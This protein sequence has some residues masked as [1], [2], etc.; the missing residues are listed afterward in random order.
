MR[1][2]HRSPIHFTVA[3]VVTIVS[4][5]GA[6]AASANG[7]TIVTTSRFIA[8]SNTPITA[9]CGFTVLQTATL[10]SRQESFTDATG[11]LVLRRTH[12][13]FNGFLIKAS[14]GEALPW[15]GNWTQTLDVA[16]GTITIDGMRQEIKS[17]GEP[18]AA[19]MVGHLV[20]SSNGSLIA[21]DESTQADFL[22]FFS[23]VC[24]VFA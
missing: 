15:H 14:T 9:V 13:S 4:L 19:M 8:P 12:V 10:D 3:T 16:A 7:P 6:A 5:V 24:P 21:L 22:N 18:P 2:L 1:L 23:A 11:N 17:P 20:I